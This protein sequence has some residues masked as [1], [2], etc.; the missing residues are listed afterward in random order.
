MPR[1]PGT[2]AQGPVSQGPLSQGPLSQGSASSGQ[3]LPAERA[4]HSQAPVAPAGA[5]DPGAQASADSP[6]TLSS[7]SDVRGS[8]TIT[9]R[10]LEAELNRLEAELA[11]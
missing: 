7:A 5:D 10:H 6:N 11:N 2:S 3:P 4:V 9:R 1:A 8:E